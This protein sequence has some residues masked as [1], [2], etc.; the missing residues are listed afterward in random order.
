MMDKNP[1][2]RTQSCAE[3]AARLEPWA[4]QSADLPQPR[5]SRGPWSAPP[6]PQLD[7]ESTATKEDALQETS[8]NSIDSNQAAA[9]LPE[10]LSS[11]AQV[12]PDTVVKSGR[13][14][15]MLIAL[16][17]AI[18]LPPALLIG[19]IVGYLAALK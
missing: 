2:N 7:T 19:A 1:N 8:I 18:L 4:V 5:M 6:L 13:S 11:V 3:V 12:L 16:T 10:N 14:A 9:L 17:V 15:G